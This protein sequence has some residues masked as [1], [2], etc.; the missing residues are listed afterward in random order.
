MLMTLLLMM[1][2]F[3]LKNIILIEI[4]RKWNSWTHYKSWTLCTQIY[5]THNNYLQN[6]SNKPENHTNKLIMNFS[7]T[8]TTVSGLQQERR[9]FNE[10]FW[11]YTLSLY[12]EEKNDRRCL[13]FEVKRQKIAAFTLLSGFSFLSLIKF[14]DSSLIS[15]WIVEDRNTKPRISWETLF[16]CS[17]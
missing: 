8:V 16:G 13:N 17:W 15:Q 3:D 10:E 6:L 12:L 9:K 11:W 5:S 14:P 7:I 4:M 1:R 2:R